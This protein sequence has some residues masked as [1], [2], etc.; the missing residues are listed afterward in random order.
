MP[1]ITL[2][3][4]QAH[5]EKEE[6]NAQNY[7]DRWQG[8]SPVPFAVHPRADF[9]KSGNIAAGAP[10]NVSPVLQTER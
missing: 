6:E 7:T 10:C 1:S 5:A 3:L 9:N 4:P 2:L 8:I